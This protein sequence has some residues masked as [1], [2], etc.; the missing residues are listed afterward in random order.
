MIP[1]MIPVLGIWAERRGRVYQR[2]RNQE[3]GGRLKRLLINP[4][5]TLILYTA[6]NR[7]CTKGS[8]T[9]IVQQVPLG[10]IGQH[11]TPDR[12]CCR[13]TGVI[14]DVLVLELEERIYVFVWYNPI[15]T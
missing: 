15:K 1:V 4:Q 6:I 14:G 10:H 7:I 2:L 5:F 13:V 12:F 11:R 3:P 8:M 9:V